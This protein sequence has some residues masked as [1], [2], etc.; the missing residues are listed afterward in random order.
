MTNTPLK[1]FGNQVLYDYKTPSKI[2]FNNN[3]GA[4]EAINEVVQ[5]IQHSDTMSKVPTPTGDTG[6]IHI[7]NEFRW[8]K[9]ALD[10]IAVKNTPIV[11]LREM[12]VVSPAFFHNMT[13]LLNMIAGKNGVA[14]MLN[15]AL[16]AL[17]G[18]PGIEEL[19]GGQRDRTGLDTFSP[20]F[21][22]EDTTA[23]P[24]PNLI[25]EF[26][27]S[28]AFIDF[29]QNL[30]ESLVTLKDSFADFKSGVLGT[31]TWKWA[32]YLNEYEK[33]YG[34]IPTRFL[35]YVPYLGDNYKQISTSWGNDSGGLTTSTISKISGF[36]KL[37][38]P[39][40]GVDLAKTYNYPDAGPSHD[41]NFFLDNTVIDGTSHAEKNYRLIYLL[42]YQNLPNR[43]NHSSLTPPVIYQSSLPGVFSYRWSYLSKLVVNFI[44][45]R[46]P[47][48]I[49]IIKNKKDPS[50]VIMPEG[51]EVQMTI[52]SLTPETKNLMYDSI[53][54]PVTSS[55]KT[56][57]MR[58]ESG[59]V[60]ENARGPGPRRV[61]RTRGDAADQAAA[62]DFKFPGS[63]P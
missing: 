34:V 17:V 42:L 20:H 19:T 5:E 9:S 6:K 8:T 18:E 35:Y 14:P 61:I 55:V 39:A 15:N 44:G 50:R 57:P 52:T 59:P 37:A 2:D 60:A 33:I 3:K 53:D 49:H 23:H 16:R 10:S 38:S 7:V 28:N 13:T 56:E 31:E 36:L 11:T 21:A 48:D 24:Q 32:N 41:V 25:T 63:A 29:T 27:T 62:P 12:Q 22:G 40:V 4:T 43:V 1:N 51:F 54:N 58:F 45:T 30:E 46:R 47:M 26:I